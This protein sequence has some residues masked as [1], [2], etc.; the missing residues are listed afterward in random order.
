[1]KENNMMT[2]HEEGC[3]FNDLYDV[4]FNNRK[5]DRQK[6]MQSI[7]KDQ[8]EGRIILAYRVGF[9]CSKT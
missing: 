9:S 3:G 7:E 4:H 8:T 6:Y 1:M 2:N 5:V